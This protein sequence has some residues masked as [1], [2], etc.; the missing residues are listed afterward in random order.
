[1][2]QVKWVVKHIVLAKFKEGVEKG[3]IEKLIRD[4]EDLRNHIEQIKSFEWGTDVS[5]ENL[6]QGFTHVFET[7]FQTLEDRSAYVAHPAHVQFGTQLLTTLEKVVVIDY[8][9]RPEP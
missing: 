7:T 6:N 2:D 4:Y 8:V 1:M 3:E 5:I 9:P